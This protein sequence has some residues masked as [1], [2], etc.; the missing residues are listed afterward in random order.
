MHSRLLAGFGALALG[1]TVC[2]AAVAT[3]GGD[4][5]GLPSG[6]AV[7][8]HAR[9]AP[10]GGLAGHGPAARALTAPS[11]DLSWPLHGAITGRFGEQ[12]AGHVHEGIDIPM[13]A[14]TPIRAASSGTVVMR[15]W[16]DGYGNY[17][18]V[19]HTTITTCYGHQSRFGTRL[20]AKVRRGQ[21]IGFVGHT[22]D[23]G[24]NH[25]HFEVRR[26]T[27]PWGTPVNP[28][29]LLRRGGR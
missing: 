2:A 28:V 24:V 3:I 8:M 18:C 9:V 13:P 16:Q 4:S 23:T 21:V 26:G 29:K 19:A 25:L 17:T 5:S 11:D 7:E 14:G 22:G 10:P 6:G 20:G 1:A 27:K 12:R 15:E